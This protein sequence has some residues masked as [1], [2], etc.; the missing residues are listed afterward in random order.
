MDSLKVPNA[1]QPLPPPEGAHE[2]PL[3]FWTRETVAGLW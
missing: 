1:K 3:E 2:V